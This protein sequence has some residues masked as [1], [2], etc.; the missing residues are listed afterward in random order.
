MRDPAMLTSTRPETNGSDSAPDVR[1]LIVDDQ[2]RFIDVVRE[3]VEVTPG[4]QAV[5]EARSGEE[6]VTLAG[7]LRPDLVLIDVCMPGVDGAEATRSITDAGSAQVVVLMTSDP[8]VVPA[9]A[10]QRCGALAVIGKEQLRP[11]ALAGLWAGR[12]NG[13][14]QSPS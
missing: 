7:A 4:F 2:A 9:A 8:G 14:G 6:A 1:V 10:A 12:A 3:M 5:G 11:R 13:G